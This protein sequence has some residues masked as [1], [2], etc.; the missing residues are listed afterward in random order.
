MTVTPNVSP[1]ELSRVLVFLPRNRFLYLLRRT[2][3][4]ADATEPPGLRPK[5]VLVMGLYD[6]FAHMNGYIT[7]DQQQRLVARFDAVL[8]DLADATW[9]VLE[10]VPAPLT[11]S[12]GRYAAI[13]TRRTWYD[14]ELDEEREAL[15]EACVTHVACDLTALLMRLHKRI[16][17]L[18]GG[19]D[20]AAERGNG[21]AG[22]AAD[23]PG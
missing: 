8:G 23:G 10:R 4:P 16:T 14:Y 21:E 19:R 9:R 22:R 17:E 1:A 12:D 15:P 6:W 7:D 18:R 11:L 3:P 20:A 13:H 2:V 5:T